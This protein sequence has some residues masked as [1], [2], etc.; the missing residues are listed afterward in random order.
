[1]IA[2]IVLIF[3]SAREQPR[4]SYYAMPTTPTSA[5]FIEESR[6]K[7]ASANALH[8]KSAVGMI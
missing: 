7:L 2:S 3:A 5:A 8:R 1:V 6:M 4:I